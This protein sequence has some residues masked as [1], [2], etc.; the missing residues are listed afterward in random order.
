MKR[1]LVLYIINLYQCHIHYQIA[2]VLISSLVKDQG[3]APE[4]VP[5]GTHV[6]HSWI[7][8]FIYMLCL[9]QIALMLNLEVIL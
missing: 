6:D 5:V 2:V 7:F 8:H 3:S 4:G 1:T 9:I